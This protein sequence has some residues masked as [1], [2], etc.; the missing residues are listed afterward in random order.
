V[1][2]AAKETSRDV[3]KSGLRWNSDGSHA[4]PCNHL[5]SPITKRLH[6]RPPQRLSAVTRKTAHAR[7]ILTLRHSRLAASQAPRADPQERSLCKKPLFNLL[8]TA[9]FPPKSC[10]RS[11]AI[12]NPMTI[13]TGLMLDVHLNQIVCEMLIS[14]GLKQA[15]TLVRE[16]LVFGTL[17]LMY[18]QVDAFC[19]GLFRSVTRLAPSCCTGCTS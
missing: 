4:Q 3:E 10:S 16:G 7:R 8:S 5:R 9:Y 12:S 15:T 17:G 2:E 13:D 18:C 19:R 6:P 11:N 1:P 14:D